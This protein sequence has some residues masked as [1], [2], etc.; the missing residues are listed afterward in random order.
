[1]ADPIRTAAGCSR[2]TTV[3]VG[4][5]VPLRRSRRRR[6][7][8]I[9]RCLRSIADR[10]RPTGGAICASSCGNCGGGRNAQA[11]ESKRLRRRPGC[12]HAQTAPKDAGD[13][14][15]LR[16]M[17]WR[18]L[19]RIGS[20][21]W[22]RR[23]VVVLR[24]VWAERDASARTGRWP[25]PPGTIDQ[26]RPRCSAARCPSRRSARNSENQR[27]CLSSYS[28]ARRRIARDAASGSRETPTFAARRY[29]RLPL[30]CV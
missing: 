26:C 9:L 4:G 5:R 25:H 18:R 30:C 20:A 2:Y 1:M 11:V 12:D 27:R 21:T 29:T 17:A 22:G 10:L 13:D 19:H 8:V 24:R 14:H 6:G 28:S 7:L 23:L 16:C 3:D 15:V